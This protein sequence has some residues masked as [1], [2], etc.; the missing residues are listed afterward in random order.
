MPALKALVAA[1]VAVS[2]VLTQ[3]DRPAGRGRKLTPPPVGQAAAEL[4]LYVQQPE[5]LRAFTA[6]PP[7]WGG[8]PDLLVVA[9]YGLLLP[10]WMLD[11]PRRPCLNLHASLLPRWRGAA[12]MQY[13]ILAG[14][15]QTGVSLMQVVAALDTGPVY[16]QRG[17][18]LAPDE[19]TG[20]LHSRLAHLAGELL[21]DHLEALLDGSLTATPQNEAQAT[22][23]PKIHKS[24]ARM[25][26]RES[27]M[28]LER[29][30]RAYNPW[31]VAEGML[32][33]GRRLRVW[34]AV[35]MDSASLAPPGAIVA[36]DAEGLVVA[37]S[38]GMLRI[39]E[40]QPPS[41]RPMPVA[42][43]LAAHPVN[44]VSFVESY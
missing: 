17:L 6:P 26:W 35:A 28:L 44:G 9:A 16:A 5:S 38:N 43:Y 25:D 37:A 39:L 33:D 14:D 31:P 32:S 20:S 4:G 29:R 2:C 36:A 21:I 12:P 15:G 11:W 22:Y 40:V 13:A 10:Q 30:I 24:D 1:G 7:E 27:A 8:Q 34:R 41:A 23:A 3:P 42:A 18:A 19:T